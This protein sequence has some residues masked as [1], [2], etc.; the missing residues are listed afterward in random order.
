MLELY[1]LDERIAFP[2][3]DQALDE[4]NGLLAF[5][6]DLSIKRLK[7][8]YR[9][10][11]FPWFAETEPYLWWSPSPR[12]IIHLEQFHCSKSLK[13]SLRKHNFKITIN[14]KFSEVIEQCALIPRNFGANPQS[15]T[16]ITHE[17]QQ[18]YIDLHHAGAASSVEVWLHDRLVGGLYGVT[19]G[20]VFCGE[21]M[22]HKYTDASKIALLALVQ[23]MKANQLGF[24][25]CQMNTDH[26]AKLGCEDVTREQFLVLL[27]RYK[28]LDV[29]QGVWRPQEVI[30]QL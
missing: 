12:G 29:H 3:L 15:D 24:I 17:M 11:I 16:W 13:K 8:A 19:I 27:N 21:S 5:G 4:P 28:D 1:R 30:I 7:S 23:H 2:A 20:G 14:H 10:G 25:D 22:F 18:A 6:G 26:L 9:Q